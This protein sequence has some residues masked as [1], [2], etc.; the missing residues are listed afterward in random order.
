MDTSFN[1]YEILNYSG[2]DD[3]DDDSYSDHFCS[4]TALL[5]HSKHTHL[6]AKERAE[7]H[8]FGKSSVH[9]SSSSP[10]NV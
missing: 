2:G 6:M 10:G 5:D 7:S 1:S 9:P 4:S 3:D 8:V